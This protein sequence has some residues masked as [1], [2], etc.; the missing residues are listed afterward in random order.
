MFV[1]RECFEPTAVWE[2]ERERDPRI[3]PEHRDDVPIETGLEF[4]R[5]QNI[6]RWWNETRENHISIVSYDDVLVLV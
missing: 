3:A 2:R 1:G 6:F 4:R 5:K